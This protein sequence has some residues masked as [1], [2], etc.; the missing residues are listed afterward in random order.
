M[1]E[2]PSDAGPQDI[3]ALQSYLK[4]MPTHTILSGLEFARNRWRLQSSG[5]LKVGRR[6][7]VSRETEMLTAE[8]ARWRLEH[9][10]E[11]RSGYIQRGYSHPTISRIKKRLALLASDG[12]V[13]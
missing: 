2:P 10:S 4:E 8:Q 5:T 9:W 1:L 7:I 6:G 11:M 13:A 12:Y 3:A